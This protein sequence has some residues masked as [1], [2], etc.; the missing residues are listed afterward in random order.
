M[1]LYAYMYIFRCKLL[2]VEWPL[3]FLISSS[4]CGY[5]TSAEPQ[6]VALLTVKEKFFILEQ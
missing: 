3:A 6:C 2:R 1:N 5:S 4:G